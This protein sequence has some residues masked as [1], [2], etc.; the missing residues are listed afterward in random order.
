R[1]DAA[2]I[3][4]RASTH[5]TA[6]VVLER[7]LPVDAVPG[8]DEGDFLVQDEAAQLAAPLLAPAGARRILDAC[9]A[10]G[11]KTTQLVELADE[12]AQVLALDHDDAR[13]ADV[14]ANLE[15]LGL[16]CTT[17]AADAGEPAAWW[18]GQAFDRI[19]LDAPCSASGVVR[20]HPDIRFNRTAADIPALA[21]GQR[22]LLDAVWPLLGEGGTLLYVTCSVLHA[23][24]DAVVESLIEARADAVVQP[25]EAA[26]GRA[27]R[28]GRQVLPGDDDM[29]GFYFARL[30]RRGAA[31]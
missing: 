12:A 15:R 2:G 31:A 18:D 26:W 10:P 27:T 20:R 1:L 25:I 29:D 14:R 5:A 13:L 11:G 22:R 4:A 8:F 17:V 21:A 24:N 9:A 23:E 30:R 7:A 19:L 28:H 6:G 16:A 3:G